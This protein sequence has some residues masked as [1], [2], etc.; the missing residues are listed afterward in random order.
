MY[1]DSI[2]CNLIVFNLAPSPKS[3][4]KNTSGTHHTPITPW[5]YLISPLVII[6]ILNNAFSGLVASFFLKSLNSILKTFASALELFAVAFLAW[7][8][9]NDQ[10]DIHTIAA[11]IMVSVAMVV[12][13]KNPVSV[14]PPGRASND[15]E[16][17]MLLP[18]SEQE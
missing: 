7:I 2:F 10:V 17:F 11:L 18:T 6:L 15:K 13:S 16:G 14:A 5:N 3:N 9:F 8:L 1:L 12:Y 4:Q